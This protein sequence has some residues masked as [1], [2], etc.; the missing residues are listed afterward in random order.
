M[1]WLIQIP[2]WSYS[3]LDIQDYFDF[4]IKNRKILFGKPHP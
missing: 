4:I 1:E 2:D 3:V